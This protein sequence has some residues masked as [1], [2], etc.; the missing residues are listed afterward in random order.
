MARSGRPVAE[1]GQ[2]QRNGFA[3]EGSA[4][5]A[6]GGKLR[7]CHQ[8]AGQIVETDNRE[9]LRHT[10]PGLG[11][12]FEHANGDKIIHTES[13]GKTGILGKCGDI[14]GSPTSTYRYDWTNL[15]VT[16]NGTSVVTF[17]H[18]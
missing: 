17:Q 18:A 15:D 1:A 9:I 5:D 4:V 16:V 11:D 3:P 7:T 2:H 13:G 10:Q 14:T 8:R 6:H 12:G